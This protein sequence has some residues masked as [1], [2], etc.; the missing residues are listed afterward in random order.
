[1]SNQ[2]LIK[3]LCEAEACDFHQIYNA[4]KEAAN[5]CKLIPE[6]DGRFTELLVYEAFL[7]AV[8]MLVPEGAF[9]SLTDDGKGN[10]FHAFCGFGTARETY[11]PIT[12]KTRATALM[13]AILTALDKQ[14]VA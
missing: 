4:I 8:E 2:E 9:V 13:A 10:G 1:M 7:S 14:E 11:T 5:V 3:Q 12:A 6:L